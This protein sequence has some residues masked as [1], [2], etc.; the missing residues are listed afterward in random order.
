[1]RSCGVAVS[2]LQTLETN[3]G[4]WLVYQSLQTGKPSAELLPAIVQQSLDKLPIPKRMR[5]GA[6]EAEFVRPVHWLVM[7]LGDD[8]I[9]CEI[10]SVKS[11]RDS[12]GHRF[13]HPDPIFIPEPSAYGALLRDTGKVI[14]DFT[15]RRELIREAVVQAAAAHAGT[16]VIDEDLLNEVTGL[17]E[18]PQA[19]VGSFE[20]RFLAVPPECLISAMKGHQKYFHMVDAQGKLMPNFIT[21]SNISSSNPDSVRAGNERVIRPRLTDADFFWTQDRKSRLEARRD[22]LATVLFQQKL[23]SLQDKSQ[24][25]A[26]VAEAIAKAIGAQPEQ[27]ARAALLAK[28]D[29]MTLMV[30]EFPELQ[31]IMGRYYA[32]HDGEPTEVALALDEQYMPRFAGDQLPASKT[33]QAL[34][35]ADK[36]DTLIGIFGV[37]QV[38]SGDKDP[39]ALRRAALGALRIIIE[40]GLDIDLLEMLEHAAEAN[41]GLFDNNHVITQ[42]FEFMMGRLKAYYQDRGVAVDTFEA[43]LAQRPT[44]PLDF[45]ARL[46]AVSAFRDLPEAEALAAAN[47]R[48]ANI[49]KKTEESI[50]AQ[51]DAN[52]LQDAAERQLY[53]QVARSSDAV[54]PLFLARDYANA[55]KTLAGLRNV[56]DSFFDQ[57][58]VMADEP[59]LRANRLAL[60]SQLRSLFLEVADLSLLQG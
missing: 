47:K 44:R 22:S 57:V 10:L 7:L 11:G 6:L 49:L 42:V 13:H 28:C 17:V 46:R 48:I 21:L 1:A 3:K 9:D 24:R 15:Q 58:M 4:S 45:D 35:I 43:V 33:G 34:A 20:Q 41:T 25:V 12:Y 39:F 29:L 31:G 23:G 51:V 60:L 37:G 27:A 40:Q 53:E 5:W 26:A 36:L 59:A 14:A 19:V 8:V 32:E 55:L 38:P 30:G 50:P 18:W 54:T 52:L 16:A 56:V 2:E